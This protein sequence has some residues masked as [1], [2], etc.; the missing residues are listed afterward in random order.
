MNDRPQDLRRRRLLLAATAAPTAAWLAACA[1][2]PGARDGP[3]LDAP[4]LKVGD[5][6]TYR[7]RD[8]FRDPFLWDET[9]EVVAA[10]PGAIDIRIVRRGPNVDTDRV[11]RWTSPGDLARGSVLETEVRNFAPPLPRWR[12]PLARGGRW[13]LWANNTHPDGRTGRINY[14]A[15]VGGWNTIDTPAGPFDAIG[16]RVLLILD[17]EEFWRTAT[18]ANH[19][20][21]LSPKVGNSVLEEMTA[22]YFEKGDPLSRMAIR[23]QNARI[24]LTSYARR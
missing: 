3:P 14:F 9:R 20:F 19:L 15:T 18:E 13:S 22:Q 4:A 21:W 7:G 24:E 5:R 8:G 6:W 12:Y 2:T 16:V 23:S 1:G 11:E 17:D 10:A